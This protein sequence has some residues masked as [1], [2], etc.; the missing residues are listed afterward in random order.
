MKILLLSTHF[1]TGGITSYLMSLSRGLIQRGHKVFLVSAGGNCESVFKNIGGNHLDLGFRTK[2]EADL[3]IY[4]NL[5]RWKNFIEQEDIDVIHAQTRITQ[6]MG[7]LLSLL[8][9]RPLITTCHGF[10]R[11]HLFRRLFPC[12]GDAVIA[13][14]QPVR[15][16][17]KNDFHVKDQRIHVVANGLDMKA[18]PLATQMLRIQK[19]K[20]WDIKAHK[21]IGIIAR[22]SDVKGIDVLLKSMPLVIKQFPNVL[23]MIV[24]EGDQQ[25]KLLA[26]SEKLNLNEHVRFENIVNQTADILPVFD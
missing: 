2:S 15:D 17:L 26:L 23:L 13:I 3:R 4:L 20:Q 10:F 25:D 1:N 11:P 8:T 18:F 22:L 16:H 21:V 12:W 24:G 6:V 14:S 19:R 9:R 7:H 5:R